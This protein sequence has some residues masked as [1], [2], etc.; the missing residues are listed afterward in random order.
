[1]RC[2]LGNLTIL[3]EVKQVVS[4]GITQRDQ[5]IASVS[6]Y[7]AAQADGDLEKITVEGDVNDTSGR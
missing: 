4:I 5:H 1:M 3:E 7:H 2:E 6:D